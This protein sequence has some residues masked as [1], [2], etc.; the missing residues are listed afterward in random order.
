MDS[1]G[2]LPISLIASFHRIQ[3]LTTDLD[4]VVEAILESD[5]LEMVDGY[6]VSL[7]QFNTSSHPFYA[8]HIREVF[9]LFNAIKRH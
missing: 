2:Y 7:P 4:L 1:E 9:S 5:K 8:T 6:K 3:G